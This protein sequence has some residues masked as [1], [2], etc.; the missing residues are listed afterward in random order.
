MQLLEKLASIDKPKIKPLSNGTAVSIEEVWDTLIVPYLPK[1]DVVLAWNELLMDYVNSEHPTFALRGYNSFPRERYGDLRRGFLTKTQDFSYF[2]TDNF[3][4]MYFQKLSIDGFVPTLDELITAFNKRE[5]PSRY[6]RNTAQERELSAVKQG[7][8]PRINSAGFKLA[9]I[10]PVGMNYKY[11]NQDL[12][13]KYILATYFPKGDRKDWHVVNDS[14]GTYYRRQ[15]FVHSN[16]KQ[17]AIAQFLRFVHPFNYFLCPKKNCEN[18]NK[19]SELAEYYPLLAYAHDYNL[20]QYGNVYKE[21]ISHIMPDKNL[22]TNLFDNSKNEINIR[23]GCSVNE[24]TNSDFNLNRDSTT[25]D[26]GRKN[27]ANINMFDAHVSMLVEYL[28]NQNTSF[29]KLETEYL[30]IVSAAR[31]GGFISKGIINSYGINNAHK[32]ILSYYDLDKLID[33]SNGILKET[34]KKIAKYLQNR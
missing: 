5:F 9:H 11:N 15:M 1:R 33:E 28:S 13:S 21:Y 26:S 19:C 34:L 24:D 31:G 25:E 23:Y 32:G 18:N 20:N 4:A 8:D 22:Y 12:G 30:G 10:I 29:R 16:A 17:F 7:R 14:T 3:F 2:Y 27:N 6:G